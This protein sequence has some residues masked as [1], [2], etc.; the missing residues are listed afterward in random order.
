MAAVLPGALNSFAEIHVCMQPGTRSL[1]RARLSW[2]NIC[3]RVSE[4]ILEAEC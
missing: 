2:A 3:V 1:Q 4:C